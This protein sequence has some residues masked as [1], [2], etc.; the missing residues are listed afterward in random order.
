MTPNWNR[1][2]GYFLCTCR[3]LDTNIVPKASSD[4]KRAGV[5]PKEICSFYITCVRSV[6]EHSCQACYFALPEYLN[7][8][9]ERLQRGRALRMIFPI[10]LMT[11]PQQLLTTQ[12]LKAHA[13]RRNIVGPNMLRP[14]ALSHNNVGTCWHLLRIV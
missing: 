13:N 10:Y 2:S 14:F 8:N 9:L 4:F 5:Q 1:N 12:C 7:G 6:I 11:R 3:L